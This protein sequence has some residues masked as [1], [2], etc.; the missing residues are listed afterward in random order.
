MSEEQGT[1]PRGERS[2]AA[3]SPLTLAQLQGAGAE[4]VG[5]DGGKVGDLG[6]VGDAELQVKRTLKRD[7]RIPVNRVREVTPDGKVML[8]HTAEDA[9]NVG[10]PNASDQGDPAANFSQT[11]ER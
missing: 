10:H 1:P 2:E 7:L 9:K 8:D 5:S 4:V 6:E 11:T 3:D